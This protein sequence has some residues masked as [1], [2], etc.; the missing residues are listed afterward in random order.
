[1]KV[2]DKKA[3]DSACRAAMSKA[4]KVLK[5]ATALGA[6]VSKRKNVPEIAMEIINGFKKSMRTSM[7][8][9]GELPKKA[10]D[11]QKHELD[12]IA[13]S[14]LHLGGST[15]AI[16]CKWWLGKFDTAFKLRRWEEIAEH[17]STLSRYPLLLSAPLLCQC[18]F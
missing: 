16:A 8:I 12:A 3:I 4:S 11:V 10:M 17:I 5:D 9:L 15:G 1:V 14:V 7:Q 2:E 13:S 6:K 18:L